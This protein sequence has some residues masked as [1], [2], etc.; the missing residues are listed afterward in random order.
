MSLE[1]K[2]VRT[3]HDG[4]RVREELRPHDEEFGKEFGFTVHMLRTD[5]GMSFAEICEATWQYNSQYCEP[6]MS[7]EEI[8]LNLIRA[9]ELGF[10]GV[11]Q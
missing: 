9:I 11:C 6:L 4:G 3:T 7:K 5:I 8:G 1:Q 10:A 2:F